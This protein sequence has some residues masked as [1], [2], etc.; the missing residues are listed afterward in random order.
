MGSKNIYNIKLYL[1]DD[2][3]DNFI[4]CKGKLMRVGSVSIDSP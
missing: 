2:S 3:G 4:D 1:K